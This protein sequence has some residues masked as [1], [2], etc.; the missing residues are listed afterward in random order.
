MNPTIF[1]VIFPRLLNQ[2]P[3]LAVDPKSSRFKRAEALA[4]PQGSIWP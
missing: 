2:V 3:T 4:E 1:G